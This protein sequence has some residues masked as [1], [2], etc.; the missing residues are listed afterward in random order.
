MHTTTNNYSLQEWVDKAIQNSYEFW[1]TC[2]FFQDIEKTK[3]IKQ[4][5]SSHCSEQYNENIKDLCND[6]I[7][8]HITCYMHFLLNQKLED[9]LNIWTDKFYH[10]LTRRLEK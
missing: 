1:D 8:N 2:N 6:L 3:N 10:S 9:K 5:I 7:K 4:Y